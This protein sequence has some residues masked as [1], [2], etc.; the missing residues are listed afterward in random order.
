MRHK[1]DSGNTYYTVIQLARLAGVS[2]RTLRWYDKQGLLRPSRQ[3]N[4]YRV[5]A[6]ADVDTLQHILF[7][8]ELGLSLGQIAE[9]MTA[10]DFDDEKALQEHLHALKAKRERLDTLINTVEKTIATRNGEIVMSKKEQ[11]EGFKQQLLDQN[12]QKYGAEIREK[13]G[14]AQVDAS[15]K[16]FAA[17]S[18]EQFTELEALTERMHAALKAALA[19]GDPSSELAVQACRMHKE[20][21]C[22]YWASYSPEQHKGVTQMY[23]D[24]PR[25]T[26]YYDAIAPGSAVFLR[27]AVW[28]WLG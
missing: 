17:L 13:Y 9:L 8:K 2:A 1:H 16:K 24:D 19:Q 25:F 12:E 20:W 26:A 23:V 27:D 28:A 21:L 5:Y 14:E 10:A 15:N 6:D 18:Q 3:M 11:F 7:Y 4:G 22:N